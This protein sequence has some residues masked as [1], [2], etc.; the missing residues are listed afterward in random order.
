MDSHHRVRHP[1]QGKEEESFT[2]PC[3]MREPLVRLAVTLWS[4]LQN[5]SS[6]SCLAEDTVPGSWDESC[7]VVQ[8]M[9]RAFSP[10]LWKTKKYMGYIT[11]KKKALNNR[12]LYVPVKYAVLLSVVNIVRKSHSVFFAPV[13]ECV[14]IGS[15]LGCKICIFSYL[16]P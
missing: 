12:G 8:I 5:G 6:S 3:H 10:K 4:H 16:L 1:K 7:I 9:R 15:V 14:F 11:R 13:D 2:C